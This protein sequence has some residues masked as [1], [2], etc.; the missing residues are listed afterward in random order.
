MVPTMMLAENI[1][2]RSSVLI[3]LSFPELW[4]P[5]FPNVESVWPKMSTSCASIVIDVI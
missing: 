5:A 1:A 2:A 3:Q 4:K